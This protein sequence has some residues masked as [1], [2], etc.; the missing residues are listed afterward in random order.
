MT[1]REL[2]AEVVAEMLRRGEPQLVDVREPY[3]HE[4]GRIAGSRHVELRALAA[5]AG[6]IERRRPVVFYCR[7]GARSAMATQAFSAAGYDAWNLSGGIVSWVAA[8]LPIEGQVAD[9]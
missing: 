5:E 2:S 8:G 7:V 9:H 4:A 6:T 1:D 3:E